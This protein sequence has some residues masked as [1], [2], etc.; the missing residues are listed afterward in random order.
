MPH[1]LRI[2]TL[3]LL[4]CALGLGCGEQP[5]LVEIA[6]QVDDQSLQRIFPQGELGNT[7]GLPSTTFNYD[8]QVRL[9]VIHNTE[10]CAADPSLEECEVITP[11]VFDC[12]RFRGTATEVPV[13]DPDG[14]G[15]EPDLGYLM[16]ADVLIKPTN[17]LEPFVVDP[18]CVQGPGPRIR[19]VK[20]GRVTDL[21]L[22]Q[23]VYSAYEIG[24]PPVHLED[25]RVDEL[26]EP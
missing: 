23:F 8:L 2:R 17:T 20:P 14:E 22:Y 12:N 11:Q 6:W 19:T 3:P 7:C 25:C 4:A 16:F 21:D 9:R 10:T 13:S 15:G 24:G 26:V 5:G 18:A 1:K